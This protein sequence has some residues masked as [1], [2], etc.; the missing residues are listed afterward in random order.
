MKKI[1]KVL[2][3]LCLNVGPLAFLGLVYMAY[4]NINS[5]VKGDVSN[6]VPWIIILCIFAPISVGFS[7]F[8]W[9]CW[10]GEYD[11]EDDR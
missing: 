4:I 9:Y 1:K 3:L 2:G 5:T 7:I 8:G 10:K 6:P 11:K